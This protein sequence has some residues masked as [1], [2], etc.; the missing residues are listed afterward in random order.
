MRKRES[1]SVVNS[2]EIE[3]IS[4]AKQERLGNCEL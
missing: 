4:L 2:P 3:R 1:L